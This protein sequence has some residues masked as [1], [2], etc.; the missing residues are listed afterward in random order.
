MKSFLDYMFILIICLQCLYILFYYVL[1]LRYVPQ[2]KLIPN[3]DTKREYVVHSTL[4][5]Q[6]EK[7]GLQVE[8]VHEVISFKQE[9]WLKPYVTHTSTKRRN[10]TSKYKKKYYKNA[11][12]QVFGKGF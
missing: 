11:T 6:Y 10:A 12:N 7:L 1:L 2:K 8:K 5:H 9:A 3:L 4:L